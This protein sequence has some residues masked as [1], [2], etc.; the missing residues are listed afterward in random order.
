[1]LDP[2]HVDVEA[3]D[4]ETRFDRPHRNGKACVPLADDDQAICFGGTH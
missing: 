4:V 2:G 3:N 1:V